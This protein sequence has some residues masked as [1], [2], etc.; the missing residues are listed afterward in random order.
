MEYE[1]T[2]LRRAYRFA[3]W[4]HRNQLRK[5]G[6]TQYIMHP[7]AVERGV[8]KAGGDI[9]KRAAALV[10]D[11]PEDC[12]I[13]RFIVYLLLGYRTGH[14]VNLM[15]RKKGQSREDYLTK[16]LND[17]RG[18]SIIKVED[19]DHNMSTM[20]EALKLSSQVRYVEESGEY[21]LPMAKKSTTFQYNRL[22]RRVDNA[23]NRLSRIGINLEGMIL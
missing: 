8:A 19:V 11:V 18:T 4:A 22:K 21:Y 10:H 3:K 9:Y 5:D 12:R 14:H 20:H 2:K 23:I 6:I 13:P 17:P 7:V 15:T 16:I 1:N